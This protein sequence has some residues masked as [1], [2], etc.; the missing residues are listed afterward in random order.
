MQNY[1]QSIG[2]VHALTGDANTVCDFRA[3]HDTRKDIPAIPMRGTLPDTWASILHYQSQ[4]YGIF[5]TVNQLGD[6]TKTVNGHVS[7]SN[8]NANVLHCRTHVVDLDNEHAASNYVRA[9]EWQ[10]LPSFAVN[11]S[12]GKSHVYWLVAPYSGNERYSLVQRKLK[13]IFDGDRSVIDAARVLRLP[14]TLHLKDPANPQLVTWHGLNGWGAGRYDVTQLEAALANVNIIDGGGDRKPLGDAGLAAPSLDWLKYALSLSDPN[15]LDRYEWVAMLSAIK[16][17]GWSLADESVLYAMFSQWCE[18]YDDNDIAENEKHWNSIRETQLGWKSMVSRIPSL[19]ASVTL[20]NTATQKPVDQTTPVAAT[21]SVTPAMPVAAP[22]ELDCSGPFLTHVEQQTW[23]KDC[24]YVASEKKILTQ[25]A[26]FLDVGQF[27]AMYGGKEFIISSDGAK[28]TDEAWKAAVRSTLWNI[29]K[30]DHMRFL[31]SE[32]F[33]STSTDALGRKG[34]NVYKP[35]VH[36]TLNG[37]PMPYLQH[38]ANLLPNVS[39]QII[40]H[41]FFAHNIK[42]PGFKIPW[43]PLMQSAPGAGKQIFKIL[44]RHAMGS[45]YVHFPNA[46]EL[47]DSGSKFNAWMRGKLF[48]MVDEI[49][50]TDRLDMIEVLKPMITD[51]QIEIQAKGFDQTLEDNFS[52]WAF[53]SNYMDA[54]PIDD[55]DRRFSIMFS[56]I[57]HVNDFARLG[58]DK[59]YYTNLYNWMKE[60]GKKIVLDY[61]LN[62]P[63]EREAIPMRAPD[64]TSTPAVIEMSRGPVEILIRDAVTDGRAGFRGG[65]VSS[66]AIRMAEKSAQRKPVVP[67]TI[68]KI[69]MNMGYRKVGRLQSCYQE[70]DGDLSAHTV[71]YSANPHA[72]LSE[73]NKAQGYE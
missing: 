15:D 17:A 5:T 43:A 54:I 44:M 41:E 9:S 8:E 3:I 24:V 45:P 16:Q 6:L 65:W 51:E 32:P 64:T 11:T 35:I 61:Y 49:R 48:I 72:V 66:L 19:K 36:Q 26:R 67:Q 10:P 4:G 47:A 28:K 68:D 46:K 18:R 56:Q 1:D 70:A 12:H 59:A 39:D 42:F 52:N 30:A 31:P 38:V 14:G 58:M 34:V 37:D 40:W 25:S 73:F 60:D 27:N 63:L 23:F 20:G 69:M 62:Y 71:L 7:L 29:P 53:F 22:P 21:P 2:Y 57:Q 55:N 13:Q 33:A 50:C